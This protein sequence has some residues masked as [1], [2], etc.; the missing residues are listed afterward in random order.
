MVN[1]LLL[2][3]GL[4]MVLVSF[5]K[6]PITPMAEPPIDI[7]EYNVPEST[8]N[9]MMKY[10]KECKGR[11]CRN[12]E[13]FAE[14]TALVNAIYQEFEIDETTNPA[15][16]VTVRFRQS[17][18]AKYKARHKIPDDVDGDVTGYTTKL[19]RVQKKADVPQEMAFAKYNALGFAY[20]DAGVICPPPDGACKTT[21]K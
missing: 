5:D 17:D 6:K 7:W 10:V 14:D 16:W 20:F 2:C 1:K 8:A 4:L 13:V 18:V 9:Q 11:K 15:T 21:I 12:Y 3:F 19:L